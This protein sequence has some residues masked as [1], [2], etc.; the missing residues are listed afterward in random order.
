[1]RH[2]SARYLS[3]PLVGFRAS[4]RSEVIWVVITQLFSTAAG[5]PRFNHGDRSARMI[6]ISFQDFL[7]SGRQTIVFIW[8]TLPHLSQIRNCLGDPPGF[9]PVDIVPQLGEA[10]D[11]LIMG[12]PPGHFSINSLSTSIIRLSW[13]RNCTQQQFPARFQVAAD[14]VHIRMICSVAHPLVSMLGH[15]GAHPGDPVHPDVS[16]VPGRR[17]VHGREADTGAEVGVSESLEKLCSASLGDARSAV[18]DQVFGQAHGVALAGF[19]GERD[20]AV[21]ADV[22]HLAVLGKVAATISSPSRPTQTMLTCG[23]PSGFKVTRC[24]R[25]GDSSTALALSGSDVMQ[26]TLAASAADETVAGRRARRAGPPGLILPGS[27][28]LSP[29]VFWFVLGV[30]RRAFCAQSLLHRLPLG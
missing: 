27:G 22:A 7:E 10:L 29:S 9:D 4:G 11:G 26:G 1:M 14:T 17:V 13:H 16:D 25:A 20:T 30:Q 2:E 28:L 6:P 3:P 19:D 23:L 12:A 21:A 8:I 5:E 24:A 18:D 15:P